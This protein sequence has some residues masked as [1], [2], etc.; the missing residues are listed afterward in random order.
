MKVI[1]K[2]INATDNLVTQQ[3]YAAGTDTILGRTPDIYVKIKYS[4][5][6]VK[7]FKDLFNTNLNLF[8]EGKYYEFLLPLTKIKGIDEHQVKKLHKS[9]ENKL[10][11][12]KKS[13][14]E[15][16]DLL[17]YTIILSDSISKIRDLHFENSIDELLSRAQAKYPHLTINEIQDILN[18]FFQ[19]NDSNISILYNLSYLNALAESFSYRQTAKISKI[20]RTKYMN[21]I[22]SNIAYRKFA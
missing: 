12:L 21:V 18:E 15:F 5:Q 9:I 1:E 16:D 4:G 14:G 11:K 2:L 8:L 22:I 19:R 13:L 17:L 10:A 7:K 6:I 3:F 20:L